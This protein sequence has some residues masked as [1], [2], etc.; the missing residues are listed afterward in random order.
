MSW[1]NKKESDKMDNWERD[2]CFQQ[3]KA[4]CLSNLK[5]NLG[6]GG[7]KKNVI[8][9]QRT[10]G[11]SSFEIP[12]PQ[13]FPTSQKK[14][15]KNPQNFNLI[16]FPEQFPPSQTITPW[17]A[18]LSFQAA[19]FMES[20]RAQ[21]RLPDA[22]SYL[23]LPFPLENIRRHTDPVGASTSLGALPTASTEGLRRIKTSSEHNESTPNNQP[24]A[25]VVT[26]DLLSH[27]L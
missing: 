14:K 16:Q 25:Q 12:F 5:T 9:L 27:A 13:K 22:S 6:E 4:F 8:H 3:H 20:T 18:V 26:R 10:G 17:K 24:P 15:K 23:S 1:K 11:K 19:W 7:A 2:P 21:T